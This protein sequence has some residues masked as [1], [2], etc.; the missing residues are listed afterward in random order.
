MG[1]EPEEDDATKPKERNFNK[2]S[3]EQSQLLES[4]M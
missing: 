3:S 4:L 1:E 2:K